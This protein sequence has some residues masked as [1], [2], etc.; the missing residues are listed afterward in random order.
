MGS[1][2][3]GAHRPFFVLSALW[4]LLAGL[5]WLAGLRDLGWA[6]YGNLAA[7][8]A[9][10]LILGFGGAASAGFLLT[11]LPGWTKCAPV[12]GGVLVA[13]VL[14]WLLGQAVIARQVGTGQAGGGLALVAVALFALGLAAVMARAIMAGRAWRRLFA[15]AV[16]GGLGGVALA[17]V[18]WPQGVA[19][20]LA[21][22][23]QAPVLLY[24]LLISVVG[25][26]ANIGFGRNFL[27]RSGRP[28]LPVA[29]V[30]EE[31]LALAVLAGGMAAYLAFDGSAGAV[32]LGLAAAAQLWRLRRWL[33]SQIWREPLVALLLAGFLW[34]PVG[35]VAL[36]LARLEVGALASADAL[37]GLSM[38]MMGGM[39]AAM[40]G[41]AAA[42]REGGVLVARRALI[43]AC[44]LIWLAAL[45]RMAAPLWPA[46]AVAGMELAA[47][48]WLAGWGVWL[49][50]YLPALR[51]PVL[52]PVLSGRRVTLAEPGNG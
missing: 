47:L 42:R 23:P 27:A 50:A 46:G 25:G 16:P 13:L 9:P 21:A 33:T 19:A 30:W 7:L 26:R 38:G 34:L 14:A 2:W 41:R 20:A 49:L 37:H 12:Q 4:A 45:A 52:R 32:G 15:L 18:G 3:L 8:H 40:A 31:P 5:G 29:A 22:H 48:L 36:A 28:A 44:G 43:W 39:I 24:V 1:L 51:G 11:S 17:Y 35:L 10:L 6:D